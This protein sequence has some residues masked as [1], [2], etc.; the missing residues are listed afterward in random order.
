MKILKT[1]TAVA[2]SLVIFAF[3]AYNSPDKTISEIVGEKEKLSTLLTALKAADLVEVLDGEG[4]YTVFAPV[5]EAFGKLPE[6]KLDNLL[7]PENK[8]ELFNILKYHVVS[9]EYYASDLKGDQMIETLEGTPIKIKSMEQGYEESM[10]KEG[11]EM[12]TLKINNA[13]V[14]QAD[15]MASNGIVHLIDGVV[16]PADIELIGETLE[17][18]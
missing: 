2:I 12:S 15:I 7:K 14:L 9:G 5:N 4:P 17:Q 8:A 16:M 18:N 11:E 10:M 13:N 1:V 3:A 6:G